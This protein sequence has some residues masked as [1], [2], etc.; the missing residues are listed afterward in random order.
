MADPA[1]PQPT[2]PEPT[3]AQLRQE[4]EV[5]K[6]QLSGMVPGAEAT[7]LKVEIADLRAELAAL[8]AAPPAPKDSLDKSGVFRFPK[9]F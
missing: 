4:I 5:L 2:P 7:K 8:K 6:T 1:A 3:A 9:L